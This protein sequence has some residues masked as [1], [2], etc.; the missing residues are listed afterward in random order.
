LGLQVMG[1]V[2]I[3]RLRLEPGHQTAGS[4]PYDPVDQ[5]PNQGH[6]DTLSSIGIMDFFALTRITKMIHSNKIN[7]ARK[8]ALRAFAA[9]SHL[10]P[11]WVWIE[12]ACVSPSL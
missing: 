3:A 8:V 6:R 9:V 11:E 1:H 10:A 5:C 2:T 7:L 12:P 4:T